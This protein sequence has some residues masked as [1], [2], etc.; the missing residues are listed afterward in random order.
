MFHLLDA[1]LE[2]MYYNP[3]VV[4][5]ALG[6][7]VAVVVFGILT[8]TRMFGSNRGI[9]AIIA[10]CIALFGTI[11]FGELLLGLTII[12]ALLIIVGIGMI[13]IVAR[14]FFRH[15]RKQF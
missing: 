8:R 13:F 9:S 3:D 4:L 5:I 2:E 6:L 12:N 1:T 11:R 15:G 10:I 14:A 7:L